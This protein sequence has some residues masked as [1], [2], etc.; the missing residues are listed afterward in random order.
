MLSLIKCCSTSDKQPYISLS[1]CGYGKENSTLNEYKP[2]WIR[3]IHA[4]LGNPSGRH[5]LNVKQY[6]PSHLT[7]ASSEWS[8]LC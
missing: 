8:Q 4:S 3:L 1:T 6:V 2:G 5:K 7:P